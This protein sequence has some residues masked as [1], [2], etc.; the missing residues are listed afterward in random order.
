[1][2]ELPEVETM[3]RD[4]APLLDGAT[5]TA[6]WWDWERA[7]RHPSPE[8]FRDGLVGRTVCGVSRRA[9]WLVIDLDDGAALVV[10]VKMTGQLFVLPAGTRHDRHVHLRLTLDAGPVAGGGRTDGPRWLLYRDVRKFGRVGLYR[11][12]PRGELLAADE[13]ELFGKHGP[14]PLDAAF[15]LRRFRARLRARRGRLKPLIMDQAF[16]AGVG[17]IYADEALWRAGLHPLRSVG[18]LRPTQERR[19]YRAIRDVLGEAVA[20]RGS[21]VDQYTA[22]EGDGAMQGYLDVYQRTGLP[23]HRC[24]RP[25]R[26]LVLAQRGTH[27]CSWC[28]RL[29]AIDRQGN[30]AT[31]AAGARR[32]GRRGRTWSEL[33]GPDAEG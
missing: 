10:Q 29:P 25:I 18:T 27:F 26:R 32:T 9:K 21:S 1:M 16:L 7:I 8:R 31:L 2:P 6:A 11:R 30:T 3:A 4:L 12:G 33:G 23:C 17:N 15:T 13:A 5:I 24:G 28:Q 20:R 22:P 14:E 19:L